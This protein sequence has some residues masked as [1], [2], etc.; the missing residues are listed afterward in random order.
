[1]RITERRLR[2]IIRSVIKESTTMLGRKAPTEMDDL[3]HDL[4]IHD[5]KFFRI[6]KKKDEDFD[7]ELISDLEN[8]IIIPVLR[9]L[10]NK[11][12]LAG[13][14]DHTSH[15]EIDYDHESVGDAIANMSRENYMQ[16]VDI[17]R[18]KNKK[19]KK[20]KMMEI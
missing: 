15:P 2:S 18:E 1:M 16:L 6:D 19:F 13:Y 3:L 12:H 9:N 11:N 20:N 17:L 8:S 14:L 10:D 7:F 4:G 5:D